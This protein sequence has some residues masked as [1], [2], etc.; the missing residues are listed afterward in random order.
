MKKFLMAIGLCGVCATALAQ[1][2]APNTEQATQALQNAMQREIQDLGASPRPGFD[3]A[4]ASNV[5]RSLQ[6]K[7]V[8]NCEAS[9]DGVVTCTVRTSADVKGSRHEDSNRYNFYQQNGKWEARL[10]SSP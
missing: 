1:Q 4:A 9:S 5:V 6:V 3:G 7:S 2:Q 8:D 10:P